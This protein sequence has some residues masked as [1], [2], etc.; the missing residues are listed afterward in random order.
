MK[1]KETKTKLLEE[2]QKYGNVWYACKRLGVHRSTY[3]RWF[4]QDKQFKKLAQM[5]VKHGQE[6]FCELAEYA[7]GK[8]LE[9]EDIIA[10]KYAL[11]HISPRYKPSRTSK[12]ILEHHRKLMKSDLPPPITME[13]IIDE[14]DKREDEETESPPTTQTYPAAQ[15][16]IGTPIVLSNEPEDKEETELPKKHVPPRRLFLSNEE[17]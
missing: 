6:N 1:D 16:A 2:L 11:S 10:I 12:V 13:D 7:L 8:R 3:Y 9:A 5:A 17:S 14:M 15:N 4:D